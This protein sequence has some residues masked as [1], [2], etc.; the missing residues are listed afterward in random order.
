MVI[1]EL[2]VVDKEN[3]SVNTPNQRETYVNV[4]KFNSSRISK[5]GEGGSVAAAGAGG[6]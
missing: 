1:N 3:K 4:G 5:V 6:V 2:I